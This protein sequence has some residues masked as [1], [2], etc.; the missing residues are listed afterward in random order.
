M[1]TL[2]SVRT[3]STAISDRQIQERIAAQDALEYALLNVR[4]TQ[5]L[6]RT[7]YQTLERFGLDPLP[8]RKRSA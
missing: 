1:P 7:C 3:H 4:P 2:T 5:E 6:V 8:V